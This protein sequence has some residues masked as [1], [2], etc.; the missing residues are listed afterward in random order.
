M[1]KNLIKK[2]FAKNL[3]GYNKNAKIQKRM[4]HKLKNY[5]SQKHYNNILEIGCGTGFLT[6]QINENIT[7]NNYIAVD[8]VPTCKDFISNI[9]KKIEFI[10]SDIEEF[11]KQCGQ[12]YDLI[13]SNASLQWT[14]SFVNTVKSLHCLL[15]HDGELIF[16]TFG[17]ENFREIYKI[18]GLTLEYYSTEELKTIFKEYDT[19]IEEEIYVTNYSSP[20]EV[21]KHLQITGVNALVENE[22]WT[23]GKLLEFEHFYKNICP[24]MIT[25]TY[26]PIYLKL[27]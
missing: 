16:S 10:E 15:N 12:K 18:L 7:F 14:E 22:R 2:R 4:A 9:N 23:K 21:L 17:K 5:L 27:K 1:N 8:I 13:I 26:N 20:R 3:D 25:L 19:T 6:K 11:L 24:K